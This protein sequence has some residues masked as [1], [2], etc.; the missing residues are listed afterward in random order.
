M[1]VVVV[2]GM[3]AL[4]R[5]C[6]TKVWCRLGSVRVVQCGRKLARSCYRL[7]DRS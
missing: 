3:V 4:V 5:R 7:V 2:V 1:V 6:S